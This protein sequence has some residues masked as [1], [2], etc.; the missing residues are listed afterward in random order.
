MTL[1]LLQMPGWLQAQAV[2]HV[3]ME[4]SWRLRKVPTSISR[5][6]PRS[7]IIGAPPYKHG[8]HAWV[9][10][11]AR[12]RRALDLTLVCAAGREAAVDVEHRPGVG[13]RSCLDQCRNHSVAACVGPHWREVVPGLHGSRPDA[14]AAMEV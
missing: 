2:T 10:S 3:A 11:S 5:R 4:S 7:W 14:P 13:W 1:D 9:C 12:E 6:S 8:L